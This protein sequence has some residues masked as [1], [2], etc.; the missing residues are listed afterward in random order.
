[1]ADSVEQNITALKET[2]RRQEEFAANFAH[3]L[4]TPLT[5]I[6][7][8]SDMLRSRELPPESIF[9]FANY[10][11]SEGRRL[12]SL[13]L[14]LMDLIVLGHQQ[15][16]LR[17]VHCETLLKETAAVFLPAAGQSRASIEVEAEPGIVQA[18]PDLIKTCLLYTS[19]KA[20]TSGSLRRLKRS[21]QAL[22]WSDTSM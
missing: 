21:I 18:E 11:H 16:E 3:E 10:I 7:G 8:Y 15:F 2:A 6:I 19:M 1:M 5:S 13:S 20:T 17:P 22:I 4:K 14:K 12:E 9:S